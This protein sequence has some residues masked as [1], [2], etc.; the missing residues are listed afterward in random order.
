MKFKAQI[1]VIGGSGLYAMSKAKVIA[2]TS[3]KTPF[4]DPSDKITIAEIDG[5][6][7]AFL[8][9][10]GLGHRILPSEINNRANIFA[11]KLLGVRKLIGVGAAGRLKEELA[12]KHPVVS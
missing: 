5:I 2:Q 11:M 7:V 9:R 1:G 4:G 8:P 12:P 6:P 3:V 10:H